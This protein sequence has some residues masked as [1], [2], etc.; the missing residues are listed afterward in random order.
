[1]RELTKNNVQLGQKI[2]KIFGFEIEMD[3]C[4]RNVENAKEKMK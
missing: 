1:M 3:S 4:R 2:W